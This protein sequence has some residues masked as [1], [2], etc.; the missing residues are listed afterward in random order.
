M[1]FNKK[2]HRTGSLFEGPYKSVQVDNRA[3]LWPLAS[4]I[5]HGTNEHSS[6]PEY[7][8]KKST[9]WLSTDV[10]LSEHQNPASEKAGDLPK[11]LVIEGS[12]QETKQ[13]ERRDLEVSHPH[14]E[15]KR[16]NAPAI[17]SSFAIFAVLFGLGLRNI[18]VTRIKNVA[19]AP[20][21]KTEVLSES[22][23]NQDLSEPSTESTTA[24]RFAIV[25]TTNGS[26]NINIRQSPSIDSEKIGTAANGES[27]E[28]IS[29]NAGWYEVKL[30]DGSSG[31]ILTSLTYIQ[32]TVN[33]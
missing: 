13:L 2:H 14:S 17:L 29:E 26:E 1:Y 10:V 20:T 7:S 5:H 23:T 15:A 16:P 25:K 32:E 28:I 4:H 12:S 8:G 33:Q 19:S 31:F 22:T 21:T 30:K 6:Y 18:N 3:H 24:K 11:E 27:F 9:P